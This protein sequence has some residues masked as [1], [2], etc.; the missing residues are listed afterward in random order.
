M[1]LLLPY[2]ITN[3]ITEHIVIGFRTWHSRIWHICQGQSLWWALDK[4]SPS[5]LTILWTTQQLSMSRMAIL[6]VFRVW[7][8][9]IITS[10]II[11]IVIVI[12]IAIVIGL[13]LII[14]ITKSTTNSRSN[15]KDNSRQKSFLASKPY[16]YNAV[17]LTKS[18]K[19]LKN[20][21]CSLQT[22]R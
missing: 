18:K 22:L 13:I 19:I 8:V 17:I 5:V 2:I 7:W 12:I 9:S 3:I 16:Y 15:S 21:L 10:I 6:A 14:L 4:V 1:L 20:Q 11:I